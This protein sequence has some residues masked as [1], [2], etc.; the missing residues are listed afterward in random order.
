MTNDEFNFIEDAWE[1]DRADKDEYE[2]ENEDEDEHQ[3][4]IE[5]CEQ[6]AAALRAGDLAQAR[7]C[8]NTAQTTIDRVTDDPSGGQAKLET[9]W[10]CYG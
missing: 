1:G 2:D 5:A 3:Q 10:D 4:A 8:L 6:A 7:A 9:A